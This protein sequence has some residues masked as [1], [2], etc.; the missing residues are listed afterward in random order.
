M[1][2]VMDLPEQMEDTSVLRP[3]YATVNVTQKKAIPRDI[4]N[5]SI[6][7][8]ISPKGDYVAIY[9][10]PKIG[11]WVDGTQLDKCSFQFRLFNNPLVRK[12]DCIALTVDGTGQDEILL[13][14]QEFRPH[15]TFDSFIG[16]GVFL[17]ETGNTDR[18]V[19]DNESTL[20]NNMSI[21][22]STVDD[23]E[24]ARGANNSIPSDDNEGP[25]TTANTLFV[26]CNGIYINVFRLSPGNEWTYIRAI[27]LTDLVPTLSRRIM[28]KTMMET[29]NGNTFMWLEDDGLCCTLWDLQKGSNISYIFSTDNA[30]FNNSCFR[31]SSRMAI[32]PDESIV[33]LARGDT[34]T[35]Y[36]ASS[37]IEIS[38]RNYPGHKIEYV[39][40]YGQSDQLFVIV[41]RSMSLKLVSRILDPFQLKSHVEVNRVP[42][43]IIGTTILAIFREGRFQNKG[44]VCEA[45]GSRIR[46][47]I[48]HELIDIKATRTENNLV[49][50][51]GMFYTLIEGGRRKEPKMRSE[52]QFNGNGT[53]GHEEEPKELKKEYQEE[54]DEEMKRYELRMKHDEKLFPNGDGLKY[55]IARVEVAEESQGNKK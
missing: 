21:E 10:E 5:L 42:V 45:D 31:G 47:Y 9:Q 25:S 54:Y 20:L 2:S 43:P 48:S 34:L 41:R 12:P 18:E 14:R 17:T 26:A 36:F 28:C 7:L 8:A 15:S 33:A 38:T 29:I 11:Q 19:K 1:G 22:D 39:G 24:S 4:N 44:L 55:W 32:S 40:F 16:Y 23:R 3:S 50:P 46:C 52:E 27:R 35:T 53:E 37:G 13:E 6:G 49:D 51:T 30:R